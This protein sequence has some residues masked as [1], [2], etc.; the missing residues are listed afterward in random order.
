MRL[1]ALRLNAA[2]LRTKV[3][4]RVLGLFIVCALVP[5]GAMSV[6][7]YLTVSAQLS[8]QSSDRLTQTGKAL[9]DG[10]LE[11]LQFID[12][13]LGM[14]TASVRD[15]PAGEARSTQ[16]VSQ[17]GARV[18]WVAFAGRDTVVP[19]L[20]EPGSIPQ[21]DADLRDNMM[22][23]YSSITTDTSQAEQRILL[24]RATEAS[25]PNDG[26]VWAEVDAGY[27]FGGREGTALPPDMEVCVFDQLLRTLFC[28]SP[29]Q[30]RVRSAMLET[31]AAEDRGSFEW[32]AGREKYLASYR[33]M[34][35]RAE[36]AAPD[37]TLVLSESR[38]SVLAPMASFRQLF[39]PVTLLGIWVVLLLSNIQIR[40]SME[41]LV[42]LKEGTKRIAR[43][44]FGSSVEVS[45]GDEF[46]DLAASF[47][48]MARRLGRQF[49]ALTAINE[50]DRAVL[51]AFDREVIIGTLL[52]R[53]RDVL[54]CDGISVSISSTNG[55]EPKWTAIAA[56]AAD[57]TRLIKELRPAASEVEELIAN[58][59]YLLTNGSGTTR[60]YLQ[61][62]PFETQS[63]RYF[64]VLPLFIKRE[65]AGVIALAYAAP[66]EHDQ[67]DL[68]QARQLA[69]QVAVALSNTR[70]IE[71]L[72]E[73][74]LGALT[75]LARTIDAKSPWT[76]GHSERVTSLAMRVGRA[77][78]LSDED[79]EMLNR[80]GLLHD[81]G[82][83]GIPPEILDKP[84]RLT[85]DEFAV[86]REHPEIGAR[87]LKPIAAY[88]NV[89]P[90]VLYHHE[91]WDGS[92]YPE[93]L[94]GTDIPFLARVITVPDVFDAITSKRPYRSGMSH[95][96]AVD[97]IAGKSNLEFD[98]DVVEAFRH[99][100]EAG[101]VERSSTA[102]A[103]GAAAG[104][105]LA[106]VS[107]ECGARQL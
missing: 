52:Q 88:A 8:E 6:I 48:N 38:A 31:T 87:I 64:L 39:L 58:P 75:A 32:S 28:S 19:L 63:L 99:V 7:S 67:E 60:S 85:E 65:L 3:A 103:P 21:L 45:S 96:D 56:G 80:G 24:V 14:I 70:L 94:A 49:N 98:R 89:I 23:G 92:G 83:L 9:V 66:P 84:G 100:M 50:I 26:A 82:K 53:A 78:S 18:S 72:E 61:L 102:A 35:L 29:V 40:R 27:L 30:N 62:E 81:I 15:L 91:K 76:A 107:R 36:Y 5:I 77:M 95:R 20:G 86:I 1:R 17:L 106:A 51:S 16:S 71:D 42:E 74:K 34:F 46:E 47:N 12:A 43:R 90:V 68:V 44:D 97:L 59:D 4:R 69:D 79:L 93:G 37:W 73:L 25:R 104:V 10:V 33:S 54:A 105:P 13:E 41:P 101:M 22:R 55:S 57:Q 11:R 2:F